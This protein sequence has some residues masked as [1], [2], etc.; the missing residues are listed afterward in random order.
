MSILDKQVS[1]R[2]HSPWRTLLLVQWNVNARTG[3]RFNVHGQLGV[4]VTLIPN[5]IDL[6]VENNIA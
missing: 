6:D 5:V 4:A 3:G 2:L 1:N